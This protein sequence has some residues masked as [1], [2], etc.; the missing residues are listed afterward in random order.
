MIDKDFASRCTCK[1]QLMQSNENL[2][3]AIASLLQDAYPST[4]PGAAVIVVRDGQIILRQGYGMANLELGVPI[5]PNKL[6]KNTTG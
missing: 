4:E 3:H 6:K 5:E 1:E 2:A